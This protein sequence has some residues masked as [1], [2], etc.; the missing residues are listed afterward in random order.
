MVIESQFCPDCFS[1]QFRRGRC[2]KCGYQTKAES[3]Q[4][5][6]LQSG[7]VLNGRYLIGRV[8]GKGGFGITYKAMD[9]RNQYIRAIKEYA[10][11]HI[12]LVRD[13]RGG[14]HMQDRWTDQNRYEHG[15]LRFQEEAQV[16]CQIRSYPNVVKIQDQ[17][18]ENNTFYYAMNFVQ[19]TNLKQLV[20]GNHYRLAIP[21][22]IDV[23]H[24]VG[25][26]LQMI[27]DQ[28]GLIHRDISP[29][30]ILVDRNGTYTLID[31]GCA[32]EIL[33]G[34]RKGFSVVLKPGF[35]PL[36]QYSEAEPQGSY[37]DVY[38]LAATFYFLVSGRMIPT[39]V[40]RAREPGLYLPLA[41]LGLGIQDGISSTV[42]RALEQNYLRRTQTIRQFLQGLDENGGP[43]SMPT[44]P[45]R[46]RSAC[47]GYV[48]VIAGAG[49][50]EKKR[51]DHECHIGRD[52]SR[53]QLV[54]PYQEISGDHLDIRFNP[55][56]R[57]FLIKDHS[58]NGT[59]VNNQFYFHQEFELEQGAIIQFWNT[60]CQLR[61]EVRMENV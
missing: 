23:M 18:S 10:P 24:K 45:V 8:L 32:K 6:A 44:P 5:R 36:E 22:A 41:T 27:Y 58:T 39:A 7:S 54:L 15:L 46:L 47:C 13:E 9:L 26:T 59:Y 31:F 43:A 38:A 33:Q 52:A 12:R 56:E 1:N 11:K 55:V 34:D 51:I 29:E 14:L 61:L 57:Q 25:G 28:K 19:G 21:E 20:Q 60:P 4:E 3:S 37:T 2:G 50:G 42:D 48:E 53:C 49:R 35:A 30:N 40:E 16:L 17:F